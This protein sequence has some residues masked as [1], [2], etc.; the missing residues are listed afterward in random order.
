MAEVHFEI[1]AIFRLLLNLCI[2]KLFLLTQHNKKYW[3]L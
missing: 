2:K 3:S 1:K